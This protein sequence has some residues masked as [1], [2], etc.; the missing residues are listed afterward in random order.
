MIKK[1]GLEEKLVFSI[2][3]KLIQ[4]LFASLPKLFAWLKAGRQQRFTLTPLIVSKD[5]EIEPDLRQ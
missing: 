1:S 5:G 3:D 2:Q 4:K